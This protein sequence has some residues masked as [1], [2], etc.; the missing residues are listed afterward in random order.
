VALAFARAMPALVNYGST[1]TYIMKF[2][3]GYSP[4]ILYQKIPL[5]PKTSTT[6]NLP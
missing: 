2:E 3:L 1:E 4:Q 6:R 5:V